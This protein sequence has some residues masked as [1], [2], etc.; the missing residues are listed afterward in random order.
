M[1]AVVK[2]TADPGP[3]ACVFYNKP[4]PDPNAG[5]ARTHVL[6]HT[7]LRAHL[8]H[9]T[10]SHDNTLSGNPAAAY[11]LTRYMT[12][13]STML[14]R[15]QKANVSI[16]LHLGQDRPSPLLLRSYSFNAC[17]RCCDSYYM[18]NVINMFIVWMC[19][20]K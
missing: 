8:R 4:F 20:R 13:I 14:F 3:K 18:I 11:T 9:T 2:G 7:L 12:H 1:I 10:R 15:P 19:K 5:A 17:I 6:K 16:S